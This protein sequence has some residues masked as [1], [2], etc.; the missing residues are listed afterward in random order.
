MEINLK[1]IDD[2]FCMEATNSEG[3]K[4]VTD[5]GPA[6]GGHGQGFRPM[7]LLLAAIGS[8]SAIDVLDILKK[9]RQDV[10]DIQIKVNGEREE[11]KVPSLFTN[12]QVHYVLVGDLDPE[13]VK[14]AVALSMEKYCSVAK[15]LEKTA[16]IAYTTEVRPL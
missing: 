6:V 2:A 12:I 11:G 1:R 16:N 14:R 13:K 15:T 9:Q 7:Q 5:A 4:V 10:K 3:N 8:C